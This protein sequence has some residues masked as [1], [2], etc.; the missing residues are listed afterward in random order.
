MQN[1]ALHKYRDPRGCVPLPE[2]ANVSPLPRAP[3]TSLRIWAAPLIGLSSPFDGYDIPFRRGVNVF[4]L[5]ILNLPGAWATEGSAFMP[6]VQKAFARPEPVRCWLPGPACA[7]CHC[8]SQR[9][10]WGLFLHT[11]T[12]GAILPGQRCVCPSAGP[13]CWWLGVVCIQPSLPSCLSSSD[14]TSRAVAA[15]PL[16]RASSWG[17]PCPVLFAQPRKVPWEAYQMVWWK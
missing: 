10:Q 9:R 1:A 2:P 7:H 17:L 11:C 3:P 5:L 8:V 14:L 15:W 12:P 6:C 13:P 4:L 16:P